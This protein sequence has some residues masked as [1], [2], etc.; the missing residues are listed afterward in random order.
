MSADKT[1]DHHHPACHAV[2]GLVTDLEECLTAISPTPPGE[3][4]PTLQ[5]LIEKHRNQDTFSDWWG[6]YSARYIRNRISH[7]KRRP[8]EPP[9]PPL[10]LPEVE[11]A[12]ASFENALQDVLSHPLLPE[13]L[14]KRIRESSQ[15]ATPKP[16]DAPPTESSPQTP[17]RNPAPPAFPTSANLPKPSAFP[18]PAGP[19]P[20]DI[21]PPV[22]PPRPSGA[23]AIWFGLA[24]VFSLLSAF[25]YVVHLQH[26]QPRVV[27]TASPAIFSQPSPALP[28]QTQPIAEKLIEK[29]RATPETSPVPTATPPQ[30]TNKAAD[31]F[32]TLINTGLSVS[33]SRPNVALLFDSTDDGTA[34]SVVDSLRGFLLGSARVNLVANLADVAA[35]KQH[36]FFNDL[37]SGNARL[38]AQAAQLAHVEYILLGKASYSF[39]PQPSIDADLLTCDLTLSCRLV[40]RNGTGITSAA[41]T[42]AGP[43]FGRPQ[44]LEQAAEN[45]AR[46]VKEKIIDTIP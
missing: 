10:T 40:D 9:P 16:A 34:G 4:A 27:L 28:R 35:L 17:P 5:K 33:S 31:E 21:L 19:S 23:G 36:G 29:P 25:A 22:Q 43:G 13:D 6:L 37:Y 44:A 15:K 30:V 41:F 32:R 12:K 46:Q 3:S 14:R 11:R 18:L 24:I 1:I 38:L 8:D 26:Q 39:R 45:A 2:L 7:R 20:T 42:A